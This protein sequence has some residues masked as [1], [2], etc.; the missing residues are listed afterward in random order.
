MQAH[1]RT[2][3][4][5]RLWHP[6]TQAHMRTQ[7]PRLRRHAL[8]H[9]DARPLANGRAA[10]NVRVLFGDFGRSPLRNPRAQVV[11]HR[12]LHDL[13]VREEP[14]EERVHF[15]LGGGRGAARGQSF[16]LS[17]NSGMQCWPRVRGRPGQKA[18]LRRGP[19]HVHHQNRRRRLAARPGVARQR[20]GS[21]TA[22]AAERAARRD[23]P[24]QRK[25]LNLDM[26]RM[27]ARPAARPMSPVWR[28]PAQ[29]KASIPFEPW[30]FVRGSLVIE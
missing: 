20:E 7:T 16:G 30:E 10:A 14:V 23:R 4:L 8:L 6:S 2:P 19:S 24:A 5:P 17:S 18:D 1:T 9:L 27:L 12:K 3:R 15:L 26:K 22:S 29:R 25:R 21:A 11:L 13:A 28:R